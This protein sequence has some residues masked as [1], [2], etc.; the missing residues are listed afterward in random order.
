ME[1]YQ[2]PLP[3]LSRHPAHPRSSRLA[4]AHSGTLHSRRILYGSFCKVVLSTRALVHKLESYSGV[5]P[6]NVGSH[7]SHIFE[8]LH[9][10]KSIIAADLA[11]NERNHIPSEAKEGIMD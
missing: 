6:S 7:N 5:D 9:F 1:N 8:F 3:S 11:Q 2:H 10:S 4:R